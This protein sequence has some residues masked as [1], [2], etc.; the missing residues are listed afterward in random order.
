MPGNP[1]DP[2]K[3]PLQNLH[4]NLHPPLVTELLTVRIRSTYRV[5]TPS[6][7]QRPDRETSLQVSSNGEQ[8]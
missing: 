1:H 6:A 7:V 8:N 3:D 4:S 5:D 2:L